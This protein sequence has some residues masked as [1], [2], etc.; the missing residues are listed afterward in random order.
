MTDSACSMTAPRSAAS[1]PPDA[2]GYPAL[3]HAAGLNGQQPMIRRL[4]IGSAAD[5]VTEYEIRDAAGVLQAVHGRRDKLIGKDLWWRLPDGTTGLGGRKTRTLPLYRSQFIRR[6]VGEP[7]RAVCIV[8][9]EKATDALAGAVPTMLVLG[10]ITG[11]SSAPDAEV[12][13]PVI[14]TGL[15][16][17]LWPGPRC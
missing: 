5:K 3:L 2:A 12:L 1:A 11:A 16:V 17:Y 6:D 8:E 9:G 15:P 14:D 13:Q 10:T 7:A 4:P